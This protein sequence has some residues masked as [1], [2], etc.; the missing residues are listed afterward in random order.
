MCSIMS[1]TYI[2][3][4]IDLYNNVALH[5]DKSSVVDCSLLVVALSQLLQE[6]KVPSY[7]I[8]GAQHLSLYEKASFPVT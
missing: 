3:Y 2:Y 4:S 8:L 6:L 7:E 1:S 5:R